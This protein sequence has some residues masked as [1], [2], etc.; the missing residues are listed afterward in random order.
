MAPFNPQEVEM[1]WAL[2]EIDRMVADGRAS[3]LEG[4]R[5]ECA[6]AAW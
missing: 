3:S 6:L 4:F 1:F 5:A 2:E